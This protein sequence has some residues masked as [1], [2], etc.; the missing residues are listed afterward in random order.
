MSV[1]CINF[2]IIISSPLRGASSLLALVIKFFPNFVSLF[3]L[4]SLFTS[5]FYVC[6]II[7]ALPTP[8]FLRYW[9]PFFLIV[10]QKKLIDNLV[11]IQN[12]G[13]VEVDL[14][15]GEPVAAELLEFRPVEGSPLI[16]GETTTEPKVY[17]PR[18]RIA[19]LVVGTRG[20]V[21]PFLAIAKRLQACL[22]SL[23]LSQCSS[24]AALFCQ[25]I[26]AW[27]SMWILTLC[28]YVYVPPLLYLCTH[29]FSPHKYNFTLRMYNFK[30]QLVIL[31]K[32][33][34]RLRTTIP[35]Y[36]SCWCL[37]DLF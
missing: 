33:V 10:S 22:S 36:C 26:L 16:V 34:R 13:T 1:D 2:F 6:Y 5:L 24:N 37:C 29:S 14:A 25:L 18:L 20:D 15:R 8:S 11:K 7:C 27:L 9:L 31:Y 3:S 4:F 28:T 23:I 30:G 35:I 32:F 21:Q 12:D 17:I 19:I